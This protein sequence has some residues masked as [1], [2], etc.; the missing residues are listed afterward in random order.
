MIRRF[1]A[2]GCRLVAHRP[3]LV[4]L[5]IAIA[6]TAARL[7][8]AHH[9]VEQPSL[10]RLVVEQ[11]IVARGAIVRESR[12]QRGMLVAR[13]RADA[14]LKGELPAPQ[15]DF[16][17]D[18]DHGIRYQANE[19]VLVFLNRVAGK[20]P[21]FLSPQVFSMKYSI[22]SFD[23]SGYDAVVA[24]LLGANRADDETTRSRRLKDVMLAALGSHER[25]VRSYAAAEIPALTRRAGV[26]D[27]DDWR[28]L[29]TIAR[30]PNLDNEVRQALARLLDGRHANV[31]R[32][33]PAP[34]E[35]SPK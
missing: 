10:G 2:P 27:D 28:R 3:S 9:A 24:G 33:A 6:S 4:A 5:S 14:V 1:G 19:R 16:A 17:S 26:W 35:G 34:S 8:L 31:V 22:T 18:P 7:A 15:I 21:A 29:E 12:M 32:H 23:P 11:E 30:Q 20:Q 25:S 13:L